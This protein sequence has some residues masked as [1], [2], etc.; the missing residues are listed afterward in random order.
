[1]NV[2]KRYQTLNNTVDNNS[3]SLY[4]SEFTLKQTTGLWVRAFQFF[5]MYRSEGERLKSSLRVQEDNIENDTPAPVTC[6]YQ[7][8]KAT[9]FFEVNKQRTSISGSLRWFEAILSVSILASFL[10]TGFSKTIE[11]VD[12]ERCTFD[13]NGTVKADTDPTD[14]RPSR[15]TEN[16]MMIR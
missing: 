13:P 7:E 15:A 5:R 4:R 10:S 6:S 2:C 16:F 8:Y 14:T 11:S 9:T 3:K 12:L 1:M